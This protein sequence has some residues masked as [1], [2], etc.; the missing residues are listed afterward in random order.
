MGWFAYGRV[1]Y[2]RPSGQSILCDRVSRRRRHAARGGTA[3]RVCAWHGGCCLR[4]RRCGSCS[5]GSLR[6]ATARSRRCPRS[7]PSR[8][9]PKSCVAGS[10]ATAWTGSTGRSRSTSASAPRST[11]SRARGSRRCAPR[12]LASRGGSATSSAA[13]KTSGASS[14]SWPEALRA[15]GEEPLGRGRARHVDQAVAR[16]GA[17]PGHAVLVELVAPRVQPG[18]DEREDGGAEAPAPLDVERPV[19][20][21]AQDQVLGEVRDLA[22]ALVHGTKLGGCSAGKEGGEER[23]EKCGRAFVREPASRERPYDARP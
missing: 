9:S 23:E 16:P 12:S 4:R 22:N 14:R 1:P 17:P 2:P 18:Q 20:E 11:T 5:I 8:S 13:S 7:R 15:G 10:R 21:E 3:A 19:E 6:K